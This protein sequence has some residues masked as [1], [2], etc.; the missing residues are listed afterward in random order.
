MAERP[1]RP[2]ARRSPRL[3]R[4]RRIVDRRRRRRKSVDLFVLPRLAPRGRV[5]RELRLCRLRP[6]V[7]T[8]SRLRLD[9]RSRRPGRLR[10]A[11]PRPLSCR[12]HRSCFGRRSRGRARLFGRGR[13]RRPGGGP[14]RRGAPRQARPPNRRRRRLAR[15]AVRG[16]CRGLARSRTVRD[17]AARAAP[18]SRAARTAAFACA[19]ARVAHRRRRRRLQAN[20]GALHVQPARKPGRRR[21]LVGREGRQR[22]LCSSRVDTRRRHRVVAVAGS[23][24]LFR[25]RNLPDTLI[26]YDVPQYVFRF[27]KVIQ[28]ALVV[29]SIP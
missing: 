5:V 10:P 13:G 11:V 22:E 25:R 20:I 6:L 28:A 14:A 9:G 18:Q 26:L 3:R 16:P 23:P 17:A 12:R 2:G 27:K 29:L 19:D 24:L 21:W 15:G 4:P 1:R 7:H 8:V